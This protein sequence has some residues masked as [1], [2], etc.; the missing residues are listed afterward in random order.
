MHLTTDVKLEVSDKQSLLDFITTSNEACNYISRVAFETKTFNAIKLQG[1]VYYDAQKQYGLKSRLVLV[2]IRKVVDAYKKD[3]K[4]LRLFKSQSLPLYTHHYKKG[5]IL[6]FYGFKIPFQARKD[7][8]LSSKHQAVLCYRN[9]KFI[10]HQPLDVE[11]QLM[12]SVTSCFGVDLGIKNIAVDSD[13]EF[14]SG[15]QV[16]GL[17][18]RHNRLRKKL[19][20]KG[21]NAI[22]A[23]HNCKYLGE[24]CGL[25]KV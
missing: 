13:G 20:A 19:Q 2:L 9:G 21:N 6:S 11:E 8:M 12:Q 15:K 17:R 18:K 1:L 4:I 23:E 16:N 14:H 25:P 3:K 7:V 10:V 22:A 5:N 24:L